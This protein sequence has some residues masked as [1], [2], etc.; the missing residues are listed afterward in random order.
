MPAQT[1][2]AAVAAA[3]DVRQPLAQPPLHAARRDQHQL[4]G[5]RVGQRIGQQCTEAVGKQVGALGTVEVEGH[6]PQR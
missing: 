1:P 5:E 6:R 3:E 2:S 4:L